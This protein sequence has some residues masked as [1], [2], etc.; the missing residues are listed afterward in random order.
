PLYEQAGVLAKVVTGSKPDAVYSGSRLA[1][2]LKVMDI[3]LTSMGD[4]AGTG[5]DT[6]IVSHSDPVQGTYKKLVIRDNRLVGAVLLGT[7]DPGG[8]LRRLFKENQPL[9]A[10]A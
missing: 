2:T 8:K 3:D 5:P 9:P 7:G 4:V 10:S 1:T 6:E